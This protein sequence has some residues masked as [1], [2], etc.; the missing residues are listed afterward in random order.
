MIRVISIHLLDLYGSLIFTQSP[1]RPACDRCLLVD[2]VPSGT[3]SPMLPYRPVSTQ[4]WE[5]HGEF[6]RKMDE[7]GTPTWK[8]PVA[9]QSRTLRQMLRL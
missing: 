3:G 9:P 4:V 1:D 5:P 2:N 7:H 8:P 6:S